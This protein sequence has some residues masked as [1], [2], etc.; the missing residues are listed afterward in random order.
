M[1]K[2]AH[3]AAV[4]R[5]RVRDSSAEDES[6]AQKIKISS[7]VKKASKKRTSAAASDID[8][9]KR[10]AEVKSSASVAASKNDV[11]AE[12][13]PTERGARGKGKTAQLK[14]RAASEIKKQI[15]EK[16]KKHASAIS[17]VIYLGHIPHGFYEKEITKFFGQFGEVKRVKLF[18]SEKTGGSKGY[19]FIQFEQADVAST[20][21]PAMNGYFLGERQLVC[22]LVPANKLH[23]G[24]FARLKDN[25]KDVNTELV[26]SLEVVADSADA[27]LIKEKSY[28]KTQRTHQKKLAAMGI[29]FDILQSNVA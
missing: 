25:K 26:A 6:D 2:F 4:T 28:L 16:A 14:K 3:E 13:T 10:E 22:Q 19:A 18:R 27:S 29:D 15:E 8:E 20:A 17:T 9:D 12:S 7:V 21:A 23:R 24:M 5:K 11:S 1:S